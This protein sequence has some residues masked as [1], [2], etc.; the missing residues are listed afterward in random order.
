MAKEDEGATSTAVVPQEQSKALVPIHV[1]PPAT[2]LPTIPE[3][4]IIKTIA[5][6][7][8]EARG[9]AVPAGIDSPE[10]A[11]AVMLAGWELGLKPM[12]ALRHCFV[13]NGRTEPDAQAMMGVVQARD[14]TARFVF[15]ERTREACEVELQRGGQTIIRS[16]YTIEDAQA[17][18]QTKREGSPWRLYP[19]DMLAWAAVK[20]A[21][22]FGAPDLINAIA[23][24]DVGEAAEVMDALPTEAAEA[25][26]A[27]AIPAEALVNP[28]DEPIDAESREVPPAEAEPA[29]AEAAPAESGGRE[30]SFDGFLR[31]AAKLKEAG[32]PGCDSRSDV[33]RTMGWPE[34]D[35][36]VQAL[37]RTKAQE[38]GLSEPDAW[39]ILG[40]ALIDIAGLI[41]DGDTAAKARNAVGPMAR[42]KRESAEGEQESLPL[43]SES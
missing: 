41:R 32:H 24:T 15:H 16:R 36:D 28:G 38:A 6:S 9:H 39:L 4:Q 22:R 12:T 33:K 43:G 30:G 5:N 23:G 11:F 17:S 19:R 2:T 1:T 25:I 18:G 21:C 34:N 37:V 13:V 27:E 29:Q 14:P 10:K 8:I 40:H 7:V 20:R 3:V 31:V 42:L 35:E 26:P